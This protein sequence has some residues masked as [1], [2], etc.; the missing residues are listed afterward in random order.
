MNKLCLTK[1]EKSK[2]ACKEETSG[3][4]SRQLLSFA[5]APQP[6][7]RYWASAAP[8]PPVTHLCPLPGATQQEGTLSTPSKGGP[9]C[10]GP[11]PAAEASSQVLLV[12]SNS[13]APPSFP[14]LLLA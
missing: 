12:N 13:D 10:G 14:L 9:L 8:E 11:S 2:D 3:P 6:A 1:G 4:P 7:P 5:A